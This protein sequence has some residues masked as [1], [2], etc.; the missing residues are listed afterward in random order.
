M[1]SASL[2]MILQRE[3]LNGWLFWLPMVRGVVDGDNSGELTEPDTRISP[4]G[5]PDS[6]SG[7]R[8]MS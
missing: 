5:A 8:S 6:G 4:A 7:S 3:P 1:R 2:W